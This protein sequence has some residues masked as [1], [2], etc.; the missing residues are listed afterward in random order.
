[1]AT[2]KLPKLFLSHPLKAR[3]GKCIPGLRSQ[4]RYTALS[5]SP[6]TNR[7]RVRTARPIVSILPHLATFGAENWDAQQANVGRHRRLL[8]LGGLH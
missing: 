2:M 8:A 6:K 7:A 1:M 5:T 3:S 4:A